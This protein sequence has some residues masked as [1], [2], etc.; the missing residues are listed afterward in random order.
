MKYSDKRGNVVEVSQEHIDTA[1]KI[2]IELQKSS[3]SNKCSWSQHK[4]MM[5]TEGFTD[6]DTN[7]NYRQMVKKAQKKM[8]TL[9]ELKKY[10]ELVTE[11]KLQSI[12]EEIGEIRDSKIQA[13]QDFSRLN[14]LKKELSNDVALIERI[15]VALMNVDFSSL[16][17]IV[18]N[19]VYNSDSENKYMIACLSDLHF[20]AIVD[21][22]GREYN[23]SIAKELVMNYADK[24]LKIAKENNVEN[25]HVVNLGDSVEGLYLR[26]QNLYSAEKTFS[27]QVV[28]VSE[29]IINF[30]TKLSTG[31]KVSYS[32]I[33]GNHD[34]ISSRDDNIYSD[35]AVIMSNKIIETFIK[36]SKVDINFIQTEPYH[37]IFTKNGKNFLFVHGDKVSVKKNSVLAEQS[38]LYGIQFDAVI[39]GHVH[40]FNVSEVGEDKYTATFGS[41][42]GSDEYTLKTLNTSA[43]RSQGIILIDSDGEFEIKKVKL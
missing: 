22:E 32:G 30:L 18:H 13:Q 17:N 10:V 23:I 7:E 6:S 35:S 25:V 40:H 12:R 42:K 39:A 37:H 5:E 14:R 36:Y 28:D 21:I 16:S 9:P 3:P 11:N 2:K 41:V 19:P 8:G 29:L 24:I 26:T 38:I 4:R 31:L 1:I 43:S 27:E 34:R 15:E 20:G 33:S